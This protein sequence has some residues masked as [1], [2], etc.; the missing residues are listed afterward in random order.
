MYEN[1]GPVMVQN[2]SNISHHV[3]LTAPRKVQITNQ[4][5]I[6]NCECSRTVGNNSEVADVP[7]CQCPGGFG[8]IFSVTHF[9]FRLALNR[10]GSWTRRSLQDTSNWINLIH[11]EANIHQLYQLDS[12]QTCTFSTSTESTLLE[13]ELHNYPTTMKIDVYSQMKSCVFYSYNTTSFLPLFA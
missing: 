5:K 2:T 9:T 7:D 8:T 11:C 10:S 1:V 4:E 13:K 6:L 12:K 3:F